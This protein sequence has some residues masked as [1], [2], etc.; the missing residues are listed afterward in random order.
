MSDSNRVQVS[1]K[2]ETTW[3]TA[4]STGFTE[5]RITG[6]SLAWSISNTKSSEIRSDRQITDLIQTGAEAGGGVS[7]EL[8]YNVFDELFEGALWSSWI[9]VGGGATETLTGGAGPATNGF[10][11]NATN[12]TIVIGSGHAIDI[13]AGQWIE[14]NGSTDDDGYHMV[15]AVSGATLTL[16][17]ITTGESLATSSATIKGARLR[18]GTTEKSY[19]IQRKHDDLANDVWFT[20]KGMVANTLNISVTANSILTGS[21]EFIGKDITAATAQTSAVTAAATNDVM[22]AV[23]NVGEITEGIT[24]ATAVS[25]VYIQ[26]IT[27]SL[28]NNVR[29][30]PAIGT[31]G[32]ADIGVGQIDITGSLN[33]YF[34][35]LDL[36]NKY[37]NATETGLS[38]KVEDSDGNSYIFTFPRIKFESDGVNAGGANSDVIENISWQAMRHESYNYTIQICRIAA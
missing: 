25:G 30:I 22:N 15:T 19:S 10:V 12:N 8:S 26:E 32:H 4:P 28:N 13:S 7:F 31:L 6:E 14:L 23:N 35:D 1:Y 9:G 38:F 34:S 17:S 16:Q 21:I 11:L 20:F 36:Y 29:G 3:G 37:R 2:E 27:F 33:V 5:L 18:N 24:L